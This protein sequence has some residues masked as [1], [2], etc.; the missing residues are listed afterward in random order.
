M[1]AVHASVTGASRV[2][3]TLGCVYVRP[4]GMQNV[5]KEAGRREVSGV[6]I[7]VGGI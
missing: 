7:R 1:A 6:G 3:K 4:V 2:V 5:G